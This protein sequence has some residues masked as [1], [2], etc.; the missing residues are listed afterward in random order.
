MK[1]EG[2]IRQYCK[3]GIRKREREKEKKGKISKRDREKERRMRLVRLPEVN[4]LLRSVGKTQSVV[5][6]QDKL[7]SNYHQRVCISTLKRPDCD[8]GILCPFF[9]WK[10][11]VTSAMRFTKF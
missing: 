4:A 3:K 1:C 5:C 9:L 8:N 6:Q 7:K 11:R 10:V 2:R